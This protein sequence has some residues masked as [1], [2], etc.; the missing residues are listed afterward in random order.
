MQTALLVATTPAK[1]NVTQLVQ[2]TTYLIPHRKLVM[3][4]IRMFMLV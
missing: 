2:Q 1:T 3:V 4:R